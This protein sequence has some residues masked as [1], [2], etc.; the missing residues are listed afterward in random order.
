M[1]QPILDASEKQFLLKKLWCHGQLFAPIQ[2]ILIAVWAFKELKKFELFYGCIAPILLGFWSWGSWRTMN[3]LW[4]T[5]T[6]L[7]KC[8]LCLLFYYIGIIVIG[9]G[10][11]RDGTLDLLVV[12]FTIL[13]VMETSAFL[14]MVGCMRDGLTAV[15][16]SPMATSESPMH[17]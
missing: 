4:P 5:P 8:G 15:E 17:A 2:G 13:Q 10:H 1:S 16:F 14:I 11:I 12:L 6:M 9:C 3:K 7:V